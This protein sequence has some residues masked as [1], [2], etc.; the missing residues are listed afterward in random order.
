V[1]DSVRRRASSIVDAIVASSSHAA[2]GATGT[3]ASRPAIA[4]SPAGVFPAAVPSACARTA[5]RARW[6]RTRA[7]P[8]EIESA[9][10]MRS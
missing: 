2:S 8:S 10:A 9:D 5:F 6:T 4:R 1:L 7:A 3:I